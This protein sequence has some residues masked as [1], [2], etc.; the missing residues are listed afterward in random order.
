[1]IGL[2]DTRPPLCSVPAQAEL[3]LTAPQFEDW[4]ATVNASLAF[5]TYQAGRLFFVGRKPQGGIRAHER[6]IENCQGL[7]TD[8]HSL[9]TSSL[10]QL[11]RFE[12]VLPQGAV[13][14]SGADRRF[15]PR[16][17]R[18]T[19]RID[20]HDIGMA[21]LGGI[22]CPIFVNTLYGCLATVSDGASFR[23]VWQPKFLSALV[24]ED[25]CHLNGL[26]MDG[27][28][29]AYV[30][31]VS[32]SDVADGWRERRRDGGIVIDIAS[33]EIVASGLSMPHSPRWHDGRLWLLNS[34]TGEFGTIDPAAGTFTPVA[35]C[36]GYARGLAF[37]GR[38]AVIGLSRPRRNHTFEG[39][40]LDQQLAAK[41]AAP[42]CGLHVVDTVTGAAVAWLRI[43]HTI[44]ELYDVAVLPGVRQ[45]E[46]VGFRSEDIQREI[47]IEAGHSSPREGEAS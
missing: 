37:I 11:W 18:V 32:R 1:M 33:D 13:S 17:S 44:D 19:G 36:P 38:Y 40:A 5:T 25:R 42:R 7:W 26:A 20:I 12:N 27:H 39:L 3:I 21:A 14:A 47:S 29:P 8:G 43:E 34:G 22:R 46:A 23:P 9:W 30:T 10:Y 6:M 4:L 31:A 35:F 45:A 24:P 28:R 15:V 2:D 16:E 41:D